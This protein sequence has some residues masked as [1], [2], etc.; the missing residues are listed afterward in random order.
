MPRAVR[1][2]GRRRRGPWIQELNLPWIP[3][4]GIGFHLAL[5][6]LSLLLVLLTGLLGLACVGVSWG[7]IQRQPGFYYFNLLLA[8]AGILGVFLA[9]DLFLFY[10]FWELM[11][12]PMYFLIRC[13]GTSAARP[14]P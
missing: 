9:L 11:L 7:N 13:G 5:D 14:R 12:V 10:F 1:R 2:A 3:A 8:L 4:F 6:G